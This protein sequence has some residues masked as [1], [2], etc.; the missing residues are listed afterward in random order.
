MNLEALARQLIKL[1]PKVDIV[2]DQKGKLS[3]YDNEV[4]EGSGCLGTVN[5][6]C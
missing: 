6:I 5:L 2:C 3:Y 1:V 4:C